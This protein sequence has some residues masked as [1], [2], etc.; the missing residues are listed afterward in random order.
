VLWWDQGDQIGPLG[1]NWIQLS[2]QNES[3]EQISLNECISSARHGF[4][5]WQQET[6]HRQR[7]WTQDLVTLWNCLEINFKRGACWPYI[8]MLVII[9][10]RLAYI[11]SI[12]LVFAFWAIIYFGLFLSITIIAHSFVLLFSTVKVVFYFW[13]NNRLASILGDFFANSSGHPGCILLVKW[14]VGLSSSGSATG[15]PDEFVKKI[16]QNVAQFLSKL[17]HNLNPDLAQNFGLLQSFWKK[18]W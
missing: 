2:I 9:T 4:Y 18:C 1:N 11:N 8:T 17:M 6:R 13:Q 7:K 10:S 16:A 12:G 15:W 3:L 5:T 14:T